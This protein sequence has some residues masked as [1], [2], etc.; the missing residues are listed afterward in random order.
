M[1]I[2]G[3]DNLA[4]GSGVSTRG[5][6]EMEGQPGDGKDD[7]IAEGGEILVQLT[8]GIAKPAAKFAHGDT[9]QAG[10]VADQ[11]QPTRQGR[12]QPEQGG[13]LAIQ[14]RAIRGQQ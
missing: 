2:I 7:L 14:G 8:G 13:A 1:R 6:F 10:L 3:L 5:P 4:G 11:D 9:P 12:Q